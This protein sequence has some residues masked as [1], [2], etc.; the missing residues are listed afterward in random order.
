[1]S[2]TDQAGHAH[3]N[4]AQDLTKTTTLHRRRF[5][6]ALRSR[7]RD[8]K[9]LVRTTVGYEHDAL[10]LGRTP[11]R[12]GEAPV[13]Q[14][15]PARRFEF[16]TDA[17]AR[18]AFIAWLQDA[19]DE[20]VLETKEIERVRD[21]RHYTA[22]YVRS[23]YTK[24]LDHAGTRLNQAGIDIDEA[25]IQQT[26]NLPLHQDTVAEIY[27]RTYRNLEE[28]TDAMETEIRRELAEGMARGEN[29]RKVARRLN[30]RV[31]A[32]GITR[33][34]T[35]SRTEISNAYNRASAKRYQQ[36]GVQQVDILT[37]DP[38]P[39]CQALAADNPYPIDVAA[40]LIPSRTHPRCVCTIAPRVT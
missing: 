32:V 21:G 37:S 38:C 10:R 40:T 7:F 17:E 3:T 18:E 29:P 23:A 22:T 39:V 31:D 33:A 1:M 24:G 5:A 4:E 30:D 13:G 6:P 36:Y 9:G 14:A 2:A 16:T 34:E 28:I 12:F 35:L 15:E 8:L 20:G 19:V 27:Q 11:R 26:F 25:T